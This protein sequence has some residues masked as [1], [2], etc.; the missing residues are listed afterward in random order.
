MSS[1]S[2]AAELK[3]LQARDKIALRRLTDVTPAEFTP[4]VEARAAKLTA[5]LEERAAVIEKQS[6]A[7]ARMAVSDA[8]AV[9]SGEA[10]RAPTM[11]GREAR[12]YEAT[13]ASRPVDEGG[14][15]FFADV[16]AAQIQG[17]LGARSR[18]ERHAREVEVEGEVSKRAATTGSFAGLVVPQYLINQAAL[19]ARAGR[20]FADS[21]GSQMIPEQGTVFYVPKGTTGASA[22][23]QATENT[24][25]SSTDEV[26]ANVQVNVL[27]IAGQQDVSRQSLERGTPGLDALVYSDL[28]GAYAVALDSQLITGTGAGQKGILNA[29]GS[30][31]TAFGAAVTAATFTA[32]VAGAA[33][34]VTTGRFA[35][36][37]HLVMHPRRWN[38]LLAQAD[39]QGRPL[40]VPAMNGPM[41]ANGVGSA[42]G[43]YGNSGFTFLGL[44]VVID[45]SAPTTA[46]TLNEDVVVVYRA[47]D[48]LLWEDGDGMP[49]QLRFEQTL[50]NQL[51]VKLVA[52]NY[53]AATFERYPLSA[54]LVGGAD[55]VAGNG[56]VAPTF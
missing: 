26:W 28:A 52:Y 36:P 2:L 31:A 11:V 50:G 7:E 10:R 14:R 53:V 19:I 37:T 49:R 3:E 13:T 21:I 32:K 35:A 20:P 40:V 17:D 51:T 43:E 1:N 18:L 29:G 46:G 24:A 15:S 25:V 55:T 44:R 41:N 34:S 12:T 6:E 33:N 9:K 22:A 27:T 56:L 48:G 30:A 8:A 23:I 47:L 16:F 39:S 5:T 45:A 38:W 54:A 4:D 42:E